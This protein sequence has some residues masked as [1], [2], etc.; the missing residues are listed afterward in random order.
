ME[1]KKKLW[2]TNTMDNAA[3][4]V[5]VPELIIQKTLPNNRKK[6]IPRIETKSCRSG[7]SSS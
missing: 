6:N 3:A 4:G 1:Y 7:N 5:H 2:N